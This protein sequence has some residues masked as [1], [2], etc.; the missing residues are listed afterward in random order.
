MSNKK[1][2]RHGVKRKPQAQSL[3]PLILVIGG[4]ALVGAAAL[5]IFGGGS[6]ASQPPATPEVIGAPSLKADRE[7]V[8]LGNVPLGQDQFVSFELTNVGDQPL[9]LTES[10]YIEVREGC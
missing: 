6:T 9:F 10:P 1:S 2:K 4:V 3:N 5:L 8:D 7:L